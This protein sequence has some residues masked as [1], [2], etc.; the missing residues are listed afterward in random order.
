MRA[1]QILV[2]AESSF[3]SQISRVGVYVLYTGCHS[4]KNASLEASAAGHIAENGPKQ[5]LLMLTQGMYT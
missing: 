2:P 1:A 5:V 3:L 4:V